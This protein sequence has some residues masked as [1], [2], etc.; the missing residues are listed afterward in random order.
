MNENNNDNFPKGI[1]YKLPHQNAPDFVK[2]KLSIKVAE[3]IQYL[4]TIQG[5]WLNLDIKISKQG[6]G[7]LSIDNWKPNQQNNQQQPPQMTGQQPQEDQF[8]DIDTS[9][10]SIHF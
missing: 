2:G 5:E 10:D 8:T 1:F 3:L 7:Y 6:K 9:Y 4:G